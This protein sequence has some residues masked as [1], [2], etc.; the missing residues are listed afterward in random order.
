MS[1]VAESTGSG[2]VSARGE[3]TELLQRWRAGDAAAEARLFEL[4]Q[5]ELHRLARHYMRG[6]RPGHTLQPTAL[7]NETYM[8]LT[9]VRQLEWRDRGHFYALAARA[10]RRF[11]IDHARSRGGGVRLPFDEI[12]PGI[13]VEAT[14]LE[15]AISVDGLLDE[16]GREN[17]DRCSIVELKYFLGLTDEE[18]AEALGLPLRTAQRRWIEARRWL[19]ERLEGQGW[20]KKTGSGTTSAS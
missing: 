3:V 2:E 7:L 20:A 14:D 16:L 8:K 5:P 10:M 6:E 17:P 1:A 12:A 11:L 18:A 4:V 9:G 13:A 15:L 19:F